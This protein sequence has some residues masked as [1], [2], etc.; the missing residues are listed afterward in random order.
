VAAQNIF[1]PD[2]S[3]GWVRL[4][5]AFFFGLF[6]GLGFAGGLLEAMEGMS[7]GAVLLAIAAFSVGVEVGHQVIVI[8]LFAALKL[9]RRSRPDGDGRERVSLIAQRYGSAL[10]SVAGM[11]YLV[12]AL[13][14]SLAGS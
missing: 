8:P 4:A 13:R 5:A 2:R 6:H 1:W 14:A 3:R 12:I 9:A 7:G 10:I 11:F